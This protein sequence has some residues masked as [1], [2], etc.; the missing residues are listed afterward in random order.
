MLSVGD[1]NP[2]L[3]CFLPVD[4]IEFIKELDIGRRTNLF[5]LLKE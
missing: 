3:H 1:F 5:Q 4:R 2:E